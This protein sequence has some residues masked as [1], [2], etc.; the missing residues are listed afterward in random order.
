M[1]PVAATTSAS[2][3]SQEVEHQADKYLTCRVSSDAFAIPFSRVREIMGVQEIA[4]VPGSPVFVK[5]VIN[6][7]GKIVPVVDLRLKFGL[8]EREYKP[9]TCIVMVQI[10]NPAADKL[11][12]GIIVDSVAEVLILRTGDIQNGIAKVK[13]KI[14]TLLD[15][16]T[17]LSTEEMQGLV[18]VCCG[19]PGR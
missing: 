1:R 9:R 13:G 2:A 14:K 19:V 8:P 17:L 16:D 4:A 18:A 5:G 11:T 7:R 10:E 12:A 6:L 3:S 15:L